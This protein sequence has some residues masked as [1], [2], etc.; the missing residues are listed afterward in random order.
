M[1]AVCAVQEPERASKRPGQSSVFCI[2]RS[3]DSRQWYTQ[4]HASPQVQRCN[5]AAMYASQAA[6]EWFG[7]DPLKAHWHGMAIGWATVHSGWRLSVRA[8]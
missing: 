2:D 4:L 5:A 7:R 1:L 6:G 3:P 8:P